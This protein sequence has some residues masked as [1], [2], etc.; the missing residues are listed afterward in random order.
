LLL[1]LLYPGLALR[2]DEKASSEAPSNFLV[3]PKGERWLRWLSD[4]LPVWPCL[5]VL[6]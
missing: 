1:L 4:W 5:M 6:A 3:R 2:A